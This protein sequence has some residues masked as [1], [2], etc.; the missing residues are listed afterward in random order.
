MD[1]IPNNGSEPYEAAKLEFRLCLFH[2]RFV[3]Y[4]RTMSRLFQMNI[5]HKTQIAARGIIPFDE[6]HVVML[7]AAEQ[8]FDDGGVNLTTA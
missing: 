5:A 6:W 3:T 2:N 8:A 7:N 4:S 1:A